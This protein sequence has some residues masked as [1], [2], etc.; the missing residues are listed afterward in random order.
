MRLEEIQLHRCYSNGVIGKR[1]AVWRIT[2]ID[3]A[4]EGHV[5]IYK[6]VAGENRRKQ[7]SCSLEDFAGKVRYE[8]AQAE[9]EWVRVNR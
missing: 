7:F 8:V 3:I 1:W 6:V 5:V 2:A 9:N 4:D